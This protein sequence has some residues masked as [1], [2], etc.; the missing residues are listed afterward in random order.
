[1]RSNTSLDLSR[2][3]TQGCGGSFENWHCLIPLISGQ[4]EGEIFSSPT[5]HRE[6]IGRIITLVILQILLETE[7]FI[8]IIEILSFIS[9]T[10]ACSTRDSLVGSEA[11]HPIWPVDWQWKNIKDQLENRRIFSDTCICQSTDTEKQDRPARKRPKRE[12]VR[13]RLDRPIVTSTLEQVWIGCS[14]RSRQDLDRWDKLVIKAKNYKNWYQ[15]LLMRPEVKTSA[16]R[17]EVKT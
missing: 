6:S 9:V 8:L 13:D 15:N 3:F 10:Y 7:Y 17:P 14:V 5:K 11:W 1:M 2:D 12:Y 16:M 4:S